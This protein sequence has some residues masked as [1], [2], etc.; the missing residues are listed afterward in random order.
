MTAHDTQLS[1][2]IRRAAHPLEALDSA[3]LGRRLVVYTP[4]GCEIDGLLVRARRDLGQLASSEVVCRVM[5]HNPDTV[6]AIARR[7]RFKAQAPEGE[8]FL[9]FLMLN[10]AGLRG[11]FDGSLNRADPDLAHLAA[12]S[13]KPAAIYVWACHARGVLVGGVPLAL[14]RV[15]TPRYRDVD[16]YSRPVTVE[17]QKFLEALNFERGATYRGLNRPDLY[18]Y[19]RSPDE[20]ERPL[21]DGYRE[22]ESDSRTTVTVARS[23]DDVLRVASIRSAV[24]LAEQE[25]PFDEEFDGNDF[26]ATHLI[27]YVGSEPAGCLRIRYFA[28]F[29]KIERLAVRRE[30]R[31][32]RLA[33]QL[34]RAGIDLCRVKGY[35]RLYG[36]AQ[37]RLVKFWARFGFRTF[38]GG[39]ELTFSDF[40]YVEMVLETKRHEEAITIGG[41]PYRIIRP[42]GRWHVPGIL[43]HSTIRPI[44]HPSIEE[45]RG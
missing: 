39:R 3:R 18:V 12:Q 42:E 27:G 44:T 20:T 6:W 13:E 21:Y 40:D 37:K 26:C 8:G 5:S 38:E 25:C 17:G 41:D 9:A 28:D 15:W 43:E 30:F 29:A 36:H 24:Y 19:R 16:L 23:L 31:H 34:V 2:A 33:F 7:S 11:L 1:R 35:Q 45:M 10:E 32:S 22:E 14:E 4:T